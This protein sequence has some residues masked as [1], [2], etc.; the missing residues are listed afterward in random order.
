[1]LSEIGYVINH[2]ITIVWLSAAAVYAYYAVIADLVKTV[3][4]GGEE[5]EASGS[6]T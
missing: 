6:K 2:W 1:M 3:K 5:Q 4:G